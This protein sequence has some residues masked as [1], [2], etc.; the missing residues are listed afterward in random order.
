MADQTTFDPYGIFKGFYDQWEK[1]T[2]E[3]IHLWTNNREFVALSKVGSETQVRYQEIFK[4]NLEFLAN[5]LNLPTKKDVANLA[6]L[7]IQTEEKLDS[8]EE[9]MWKIQDSMDASYKEMKNL[10]DVSSEIIKHIKQLKTEQIRSNKELEKIK[11]LRSDLQEM[12]SELAELTSLKEEIVLLKKSVGENIDK[13]PEREQT[14]ESER[15]L[16]AASK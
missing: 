8:L 10:A 12:K 3:M 14:V 9:Q 13:H 5:Q 7:S 6:K 2:N 1:Q 11:V 4:K 16:A 15:E